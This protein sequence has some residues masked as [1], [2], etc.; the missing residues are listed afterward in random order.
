MTIPAN[1]TTTLFTR[2]VVQALDPYYNN[3]SLLLH[4]N[5][6]DGSTAFVDSSR[7]NKT[8]TVGG[9]TTNQNKIS[10]AQSKFGGSSLSCVTTSNGMLSVYQNAFVG[11]F[12]IETWAY[13]TSNSSGYP[14]LFRP[15]EGGHW[16]LRTRAG[17][18]K[19]EFDF[20]GGGGFTTNRTVILNAWTHLAV[21]RL[22]GVIK[23]YINGVADTATLTSTNQVGS[24]GL[25]RIG[26]NG[27]GEEFNGYLDEVRFTEGYARYT[28][29]FTVP[30]A[31][32]P[33]AA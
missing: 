15:S 14:T 33:N 26:G 8:V 22:N 16:L 18:N 29:N 7:L 1:L 23:L 21:V 10:T 28:S 31:P 13:Q 11:D 32:F 5:G 30:D 6:A 2:S 3:V 24:G 20:A 27:N 25:L 9:I 12:T 4:F 19:Y 17:D